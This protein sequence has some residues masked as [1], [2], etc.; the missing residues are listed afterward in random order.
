VTLRREDRKR[1]KQERL[2][3]INEKHARVERREAD[4]EET[5]MGVEEGEEF[6]E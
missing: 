2:D 4:K 5:R 3:K 1:R 6:N